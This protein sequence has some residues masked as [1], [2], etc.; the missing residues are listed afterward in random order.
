MTMI[1]C[2][3]ES[4]EE[5]SEGIVSVGDEEAST[6]TVGRGFRGGIVYVT[7]H[8]MFRVCPKEGATE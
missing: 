6:L 3:E 5:N 7:T 2:S 4:S 8:I 1:Q